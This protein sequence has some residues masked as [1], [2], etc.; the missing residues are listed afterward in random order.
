MAKEN[1]KRKPNYGY[2]A[3]KY[4]AY[5]GVI[6]LIGLFVALIGT[7]LTPPL[8]TILMLVGIP[9][10]FIG[11]WI[12]VSYVVLYNSAFKKG[13]QEKL[14]REIIKFSKKGR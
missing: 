4:F 3:A 6:G 2:T 10:A 7:L 8:S 14:W 12:A 13:P 1:K 11:L 5:M 9:I